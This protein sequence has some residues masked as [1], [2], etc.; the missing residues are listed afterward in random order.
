MWE[1][2]EEEENENNFCIRTTLVQTWC[3]TL[4]SLPVSPR[5]MARIASFLLFEKKKKN[6]YSTCATTSTAEHG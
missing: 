1:E 2:E 5:S 4:S 6:T 3:I